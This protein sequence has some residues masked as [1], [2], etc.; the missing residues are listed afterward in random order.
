[1]AGIL[2]PH[3]SG[4]KLRNGLDAIVINASG[5]GTTVKDYAHLVDGEA[6]QRIGG[7]TRDV[8]ALLAELGLSRANVEPYRVAY[9]DACSLQHGQRVTDQ[10]RISAAAPPGPTIF[11]S[12]TSRALGQRKAAHIDSVDPDIIAAGN[13]GCMVQIARFAEAPVVHTVELLDWATGGPM[14]RALRGRA[15]REPP[16]TAAQTVSRDAAVS[17]LPADPNPN[18]VW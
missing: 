4:A 5:C 1:V 11:C 9:H 17:P 14:P 6:A 8:A 2:L 10:P 12:W 16:P 7:L 3:L 13:L 15:L 18:G